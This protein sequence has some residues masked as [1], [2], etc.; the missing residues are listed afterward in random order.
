[1]IRTQDNVLRLKYAKAG[2]T[3]QTTKLALSQAENLLDANCGVGINIT[4]VGRIRAAKK[5]FAEAKAKLKE[6]EHGITPSGRLQRVAE[7]HLL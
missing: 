1:M 2:K 6:I 4:L 5:R 3:L 7:A